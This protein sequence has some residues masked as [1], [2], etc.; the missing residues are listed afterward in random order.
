MKWPWTHDPGPDVVD[1]EETSMA[2]ATTAKAAL[3]VEAQRLEGQQEK[4][5]LRA[6]LENN[7]FRTKMEILLFGKEL[8]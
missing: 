5:Q 8:R 6:K 4:E 2:V 7:H 1:H 3:A